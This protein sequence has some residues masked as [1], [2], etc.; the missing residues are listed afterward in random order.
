M[1]VD[2]LRAERGEFGPPETGESGQ[3]HE[4]PISRPDRVGRGE[5][6]SARR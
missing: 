3:Q 5:D 2:V 6:L 1:E 4:R